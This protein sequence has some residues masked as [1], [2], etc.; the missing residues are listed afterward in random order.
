[1]NDEKMEPLKRLTERTEFGIERVCHYENKPQNMTCYSC[2][3]RGKCNADIFE[4]L[5]E[6]EDTGLPPDAV[7]EY[8]IFEDNLVHNGISFVRVMELVKEEIERRK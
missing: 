6:Y 3:Q 4:R 1:M 7:M 2:N 5:A 8:K